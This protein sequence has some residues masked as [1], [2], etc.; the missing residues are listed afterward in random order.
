MGISEKFLM[1]L[2]SSHQKFN[3]S[4]GP[5]LALQKLTLKYKRKQ[6]KTKN[7]SEMT[8]FAGKLLFI[9]F[10]YTFIVVFPNKLL[11]VLIIGKNL[12]FIS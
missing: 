12:F 1:S 6:K 11:G 2:K 10:L 8:F 9:I 7:R 3:T 5:L 4:K